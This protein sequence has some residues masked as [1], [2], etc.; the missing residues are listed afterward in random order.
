MHVTVPAEIS[1]HVRQ[2]AREMVG[3]GT[4]PQFVTITPERGCKIADCFA[5][6]QRKVAKEGGN[7]QFGWA[8]WE[9]PGVY[10]EA[11]HHA[12]YAPSDS[13]SFVDITPSE[14]GITKRLFVPDDKATYD[15]ANEGVLRDNLRFA[16]VEDPL[17]DELFKAA[18][19]RSAFKNDLPGVGLIA[20]HATEDKILQKLENRVARASQALAEKYSSGYQKP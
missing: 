20:I 5:N 1:A 4:E 3:P 18:A 7:I 10:F 11:E 8:L 19:R 12:V 2:F 17:I 14:S 9:W 13:A 15:F 16:L 6:V